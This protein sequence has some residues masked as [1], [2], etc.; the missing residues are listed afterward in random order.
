MAGG[1]VQNCSLGEV[2]A[3]LTG[4]KDALSGWSSSKYGDI[5]R[6]IKALTLQLERLQ[7]VE[8]PTNLEEIN[9]IQKD[10]DK[11]M[12]M[13]DLKWKQRAKRNWY[14]QGD[15]NT[16]FFH[17]WATEGRRSNHI[18]QIRDSEGRLWKEQG[19]IG[20]AF[21]GY[22]QDLF[23]SGGSVGVAGCLFGLTPR[24]TPIMNADLAKVFTVEEVNDA[25]KQMHC[26][27]AP[28][29]D[30]FEACFF[31]H[32]W[33][34][35]GNSIRYAIL[36][37]LNKGNFDPSINSTFIALIPKTS[38]ASSVTDF[39]PIS[40][41]NVLY[42]IIAKVL[43]N[44]LKR[45]LPEVISQ[46]QSAFV[47]GR[48]ITDNILV[49]YEALHTMHTRMKGKKGYMAVKLDMSK[50]YDRVEWHFLEVVMEKLGFAPQWISLI[51]RC[52]ST[53]TYRVL[54]NGQQ[55]E[56]I[57]PSRGIRQG[58]PLSPYLFLLCTEGLS[59]L[60]RTTEQEGKIT[61]VPIAYRGFKLSHLFFADD[62]LLFCR[63]DFVE[64]GNLLQLLRLYEQASG[65]KLNNNKTTIFYS[66]NTGK[67][68]R[69]LICSNIG[70]TASTN[71]EKYLGLP[72]LVGRD[73]VSTFKELLNRVQKRWMEGEVPISSGSR[74]SSQGC[75]AGHTD[76]HNECF[77]APQNSV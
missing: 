48:M 24:V 71:Y 72:A 43:A 5:G 33:G 11:L 31:Q 59:S 61:G 70:I 32:H 77:S 63:A 37:F 49:A 39:R 65:Q 12:E 50:A 2:Q 3:L 22:F 76:I 9:Q 28:G 52:V 14:V 53:V 6:N 4:C 45:V 60:L 7:R 57:I 10:I 30:G 19:Q 17:A 51:M 69:E 15:H 18:G 1:D 66:R 23:S 54:I 38:S 21:I 16:S 47:P 68:F 20:R 8:S 42:K 75:G 62:S 56:L 27:K 74:D 58:D 35:V 64:W 25:L 67:E 46:F 13:E 73:K 29:P 55:D 26:L 40:L 36:D 41:C 34:V 44:R